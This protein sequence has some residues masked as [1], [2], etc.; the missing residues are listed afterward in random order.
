MKIVFLGENDWA[1]TSNRI[2]RTINSLGC[3][4][5]ARAVT[6]IPHKFGYPEDVVIARDG[7]DVARE[8]VRDADWIISSG[9]GKYD[10]LKD[11]IARLGLRN[12]T[13]RLGTQHFG[14]AYRTNPKEYD[15]LDFEWGF[16]RRFFA[17]DLYRFAFNDPRARVFIQ[18]QET[19]LERLPVFIP[20]VRFCHSPSRR[21]TKGTEAILSL[22]AGMQSEG[23][24]VLFELIENVNFAECNERMK[25]N[26]VLV[27]QLDSNIGGF[28]SAA[29]EALASGL[30]VVS[31]YGKVVREVE[32]WL[33]LPPIVN[34]DSE[35][36][37]QEEVL[38]IIND[39]DYLAQIR[40]SGLAWAQQYLNPKF[41]YE[42]WYRCLCAD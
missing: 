37:L 7:E 16:E 40:S 8:A 10:I 17:C 24:H 39:E 1:N 21:T 18:P 14:T 36:K 32:R 38:R 12:R 26:H 42:Y 23:H 34:V 25:R 11:L 6:V 19:I 3:A 20:P 29:M 31:Y 35:S 5:Q 15:R 33:P 28:G 9:D 13:F 41:T 22:F 27:D 2:A 4:M 30:A